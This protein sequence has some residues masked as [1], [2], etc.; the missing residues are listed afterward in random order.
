MSIETEALSAYVREQLVGAD[1]NMSQQIAL[2]NA[3]GGDFEPKNIDVAILDVKLWL[4]DEDYDK[5]INLIKVLPTP[6]IDITADMYLIDG[7]PATVTEWFGETKGVKT[8]K[9]ADKNDEEFSKKPFSKMTE[10]EFRRSG[11]V[12]TRFGE[13][14]GR[15]LFGNGFSESHTKKHIDFDVHIHI[16]TPVA[17]AQMEATFYSDIG[18]EEASLSDEQEFEFN[19]ASEPEIRRDR[20]LLR[21]KGLD[22]DQSTS[23]A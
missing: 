17:D 19:E 6:S 13:E 5:L 20:T 14:L 9:Y 8:I 2:H 22:K 11:V 1:L 15:E 16:P 10:E 21:A 7:S 23:T 18:D 4:L 12:G 3:K